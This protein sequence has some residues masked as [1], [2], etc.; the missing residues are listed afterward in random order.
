MMKKSV[1]ILGGGIAGL[2]AARELAHRK[3][4]VTVLEAQNRFGGRI[5][6]I[7]DGCL[8]IELGA[9]FIHGES[10]PLLDAVREA[11]L[12]KQEV[13]VQ[14]RLFQDGHFKAADIW[15]RA[16]EIFNR[17]NP[18]EP[19]AS[20]DEF[21]ARQDDVDAAVKKSVRNFVEGF[22]AAHA[23]R[24]S[25][26]ALLRAEQS[27]EQMN[28][29]KQ[30]RID[31]G[32]SALI[33]FLEEE[34]KK[35]GGALI[36]NARAKQV[37]WKPGLVE[38]SVDGGNGLEIFSADTAVIT[39][40]LGILKTEEVKFSPPLPEKLKA[41]R[42]MEFGNVVKVIFRFREPFWEDFGFI[43]ALDEAIPTWW[44]DPRGPVLVGWT[45]GPHADALLGFS[46]SQLEE[47]GLEILGK[48]FFIRSDLL[49]SQLVA[50]HY[51]NW[52]DDPN[53]RGA[54]SYIPVNG[55]DLPQV[56][57][58]PVA[59]TLF[60]AGEATVADAQMGTVFGALESGLRAAREIHGL[61]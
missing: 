22:N 57:A 61:D 56:L 38:V 41:S 54:Y 49:R 30:Y 60:F 5:H 19:D 15:D 23:N 29:S 18:A 27:A 53:T 17:V 3:I 34:I 48:I 28:G 8:P 55:L 2:A 32:Y 10:K 58:A 44:N 1:I 25:A 52:A 51:W 31:A 9:E 21:L 4:S 42:E 45:G 37:T 39:L 12:T 40:P 47:I 36:K 16:G 59:G 13:A 43:H 50:S 20:F 11:G 35:T 14:G 7:H 46:H 33:D 26:Q 24:I 6:T